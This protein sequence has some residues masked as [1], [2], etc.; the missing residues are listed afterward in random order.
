MIRTWS[1]FRLLCYK[2]K[3]IIPISSFSL[4]WFKRSI[5]ERKKAEEGHDV[6]K[7]LKISSRAETKS[8]SERGISQ[9]MF[10]L[11]YN[12]Y[13]ARQLVPTYYVRQYLGRFSN[14]G[15]SSRRVF[16]KGWKWIY[17]HWTLKFAFIYFDFQV[18]RFFDHD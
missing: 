18:K 11:I 12:L 1:L 4:S 5:A 6:I 10:D 2:Q 3:S 9:P 16:E 7:L 8:E 15:K 13:A 17:V 14:F